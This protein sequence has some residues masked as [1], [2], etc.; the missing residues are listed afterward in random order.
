[1]LVHQPLNVLPPSHTQSLIDNGPRGTAPS[2]TLQLSPSTATASQARAKD[3]AAQFVDPAS[4][5]E[6]GGRTRALAL[7]QTV[8]ARDLLYH[9]GD[10]LRS[11][12]GLAAG[13]AHDMISRLGDLQAPLGG[14]LFGP[15]GLMPGE[16]PQALLR[17]LQ[18]LMD[19]VPAGS[20][21][22]T[23]KD[24]SIMIA[25]MGDI[26]AILSSTTTGVERTPGQ[27]KRLREA[28][29]GLLGLPYSAAQSIAPTSA[30][31]GSGTIGP[32]K[33]QERIKPPNAQP[34]RT[35]VHNLGK[36]ADDLLGIK[37]NRLLPSRWDVAQLK[38][39]RVDNTAEPL[40]AHMSGTQ[41]ETLAVWDML[42]G[43]QRPYTRVMDGLNERPDLANDPMAQLP[44]AERDARYARA[45]GTAAFLISN[46]YHS[47]VEVL[48]GTLAYTGQ[49]GQSVVGPRQDAGHLF[50]Q[51]AATQLIG[52]L[53]NTQRAERA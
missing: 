6:A 13:K 28:I 4:R 48:G 32:A 8:A 46:G 26:G 1:M 11:E 31:G 23:A 22:A 12:L 15:E 47:A 17:T 10:T 45:A 43:E 3:Q 7:Q 30:L 19:D 49:D 35:G 41:A 14:H 25:L 27:D 52:E 24:R 40:I 33:K 16:K 39:E 50:G 2:P 37:S 34:L 44:P 53:L 9:P 29:P 42:R 51:G 21:S 18:R 5:T 36:E 38:K 20:N